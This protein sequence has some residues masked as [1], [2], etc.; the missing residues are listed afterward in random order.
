MVREETVDTRT[1]PL[2]K[3]LSCFRKSSI[4]LFCA[5]N[6]ILGNIK[7]T[8]AASTVAIIALPTVEY[9]EYATNT[10]SLKLFQ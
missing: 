1:H 6:T 4:F 7:D 10:S 5:A 3:I 2:E 9:T 8:I